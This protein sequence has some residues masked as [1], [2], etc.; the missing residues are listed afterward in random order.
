MRIA[1]SNTVNPEKPF[2]IRYACRRDNGSLRSFV[3]WFRVGLWDGT[4]RLI[5]WYAPRNHYCPACQF[6]FRGPGCLLTKDDM[7]EPTEEEDLAALGGGNYH[8]GHTCAIC[9]ARIT[10][11]ATYC[12]RCAKEIIKAHRLEAMSEAA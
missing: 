12:N 3:C 1:I 11:R 7:P 5:M 4:T 2:V 10:D 6:A 9:H 8:R